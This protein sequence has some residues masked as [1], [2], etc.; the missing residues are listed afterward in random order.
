MPQRRAGGRVTAHAEFE[1]ESVTTALLVNIDVDDLTRGIDF[2]CRALGLRTGRRFGGSGV[3]LLGGSAP[4]YLLEKSPGSVAAAGLTQQRDYL[5]HW[6]LG[7]GYDEM[8][9]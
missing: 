7:R 9:D 8:V 4:I 6:F 5:R 1:V 2:Y 3:E